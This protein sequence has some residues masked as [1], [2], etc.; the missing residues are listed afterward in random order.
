MHKM[1]VADMRM[2][3][4]MCGKIRNDK[5]INMSFREYIGVTLMGDKIRGTRWW[6]FGHIQRKLAMILVRKSLAIH[7]CS[8][9]RGRGRLKKTW[10]E[11]VKIDLK[12]WNLF[13]NFAQ[14]RS[15][16]RNRIHVA[17]PNIV[18]ARLWWWQWWWWWT[19]K[20]IS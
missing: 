12:T 18:G 10:M 1:D 16:Q 15:E 5:I 11:V 14:D 20:F 2:L 3:R 8:P 9:P 17:D 7:G 4:W 6:L 19:S 13:E